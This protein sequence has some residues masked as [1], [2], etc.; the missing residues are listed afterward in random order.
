[1]QYLYSV[2]V[3][4]DQSRLE[5]VELLFSLIVSVT[6]QTVSVEVQHKIS[7]VRMPMVRLELATPR[8]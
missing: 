3:N 6:F 8:L 1:M 7:S 2:C 5:Q 4:I